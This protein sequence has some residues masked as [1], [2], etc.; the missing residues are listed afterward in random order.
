MDV[1]I[2]TQRT[3]DFKKS[4][5]QDLGSMFVQIGWSLAT[6]SNA[7]NY[8]FLTS[9]NRIWYIERCCLVTGIYTLT[10]FNKRPEGWNGALIE[11]QGHQHCH[12]FVGYKSMTQL[13]GTLVQR[14]LLSISFDFELKTIC[15]QL[16]EPKNINN[17]S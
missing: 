4:W 1:R 14:Y 12:D 3:K 11:V 15:I 7:L 5:Y 8:K 9:Y 13:Q 16:F 6:C 10:C 2:Q 17:C